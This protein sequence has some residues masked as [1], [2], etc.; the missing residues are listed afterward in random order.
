[1]YALVGKRIGGWNVN[2][3]QD[4][5]KGVDCFSNKIFYY[6]LQFWDLS[7]QRSG[8]GGIFPQRPSQPS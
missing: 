2:V 6:M 7:G 5:E 1:M 4:V 3:K 8:I